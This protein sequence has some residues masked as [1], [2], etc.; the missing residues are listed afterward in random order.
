VHLCGGEGVCIT[1]VGAAIPCPFGDR[2]RKHGLFATGASV[3]AGMSTCHQA[4]PPQRFRCHT[5]TNPGAPRTAPR[6]LVSHP[7]QS[8]MQLVHTHCANE[9]RDRDC[10][11]HRVACGV[12]RA[13]AF[14]FAQGP[15]LSIPLAI[16]TVMCL[17]L[18]NKNT[19]SPY[20]KRMRV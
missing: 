17:D 3:A 18:C 14:A 15:F 1:D 19:W 7:V 10:T 16:R 12:R 20:H 4:F 8:D 11:V 9:G 2:I 13:A 5:V 6:L